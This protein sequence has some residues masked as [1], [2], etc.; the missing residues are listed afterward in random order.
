MKNLILAISLASFPQHASA[1][2]LI[3][4]PEGKVVVP[5][6]DGRMKPVEIEYRAIHRFSG[7]KLYLTDAQNN[8]GEYLYGDVQ[9]IGHNRYISGYKTI[10]F[11]ADNTKAIVSHLDPASGGELYALN[12]APGLK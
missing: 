11:G 8:K 4:V 12:C 10:A 2:D 3:C 1:L 9:E 7:S 5:R 6:S